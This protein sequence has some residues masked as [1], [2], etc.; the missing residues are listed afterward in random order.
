MTFT[1]I[2]GVMSIGAGIIGIDNKVEI[3]RLEDKT[4]DRFRNLMTVMDDLNNGVT[5][6]RLEL[7]RERE[8]RLRQH[9]LQLQATEY[10][11]IIMNLA[12][13]LRH[14]FTNFYLKKIRVEGLA[15][16]S[17]NISEYIPVKT[18]TPVSC[19][20]ESRH[21]VMDLKFTGTEI[22]RHQVLLEANPFKLYERRGGQICVVEYTGTKTV[23]WD[24]DNDSKCKAMPVLD[25]DLVLQTNTLSVC[26]PKICG[27]GEGV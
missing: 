26:L 10:S 23:M 13:E 9:G 20:W 12:G 19:T 18:L 6:L 24:K 8:Q 17:L 22:S 16:L 3:K 2:A 14:F 4:S 15:T 21:N 11:S 7:E 27:L 1:G 25:G 5:Q